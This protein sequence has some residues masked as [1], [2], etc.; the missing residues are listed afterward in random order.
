[1]EKS[2]T[3]K[4]A[5]YRNY[6]Y[7][8]NYI[9]VDGFKKTYEWSGSKNGIVDIKEIPEEVVQ[10]LMMNT[11]TFSDGELKVIEDN[12]EAKE[13][14][15]NL[16]EEYKN[17]SHS[18]EELTKLLEGNFLKMKSE[19]N[20]ITDKLELAYII[21][22]AKEIKLDSNSKLAFL[23]EKMNI[24]QDILFDKEKDEE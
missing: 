18:K 3:I 10:H 23:A 7:I 19:I 12:D 21:D 11:V 15:D 14:V 17:N 24:P 22:I 6:P 16:G 1:M 5:R 2:K 20:K 9:S 8:V 13:V 4:L